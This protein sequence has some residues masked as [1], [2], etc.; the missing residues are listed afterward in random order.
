M[1][2]NKFGHHV[3]KKL[4]MDSS[5]LENIFDAQHKIIKHVGTPIDPNDCATK[6]YVDKFLDGLYIRLKTV[7][8]TLLQLK[9]EINSLK[10]NIEGVSRKFKK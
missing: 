7:E 8:E 5:A 6:L 10:R 1:N 9:S 4:K 2:V 3:H